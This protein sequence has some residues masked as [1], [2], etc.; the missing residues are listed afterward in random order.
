MH[1]FVSTN[2]INLVFLSNIFFILIMFGVRKNIINI[3]DPLLQ[4]IIYGSISVATLI[5]VVPLSQNGDYARNYFIFSYIFIFLII[6]IFPTKVSDFS[7]IATPIILRSK[8][9]IIMFLL[10][11]STGSI[12][13]VNFIDSGLNYE[14]RALLFSKFRII[15]ILRGAST[16][17]FAFSLGFV[18]NNRK[19]L[20]WILPI[21]FINFFTGSK[22]YLINIIANF[23][24]GRGI[25]TDY[26]LDFR[27]LIFIIILSYF[28]I[29]FLFVIQSR[30]NITWNIY[31]RLLASGDIY[32]HGLQELDIGRLDGIYNIFTYIIHPITSLFGFRMY[33][34]SLGNEIQ[35]Q[36]S[37]NFNAGG[38]NAG[39]LYLSY[40]SLQEKNYVIPFAIFWAFTLIFSRK[41]VG[42]LIKRLTSHNIL[43]YDILS[44]AI[45]YN[46]LT[47]P[48]IIFLDVGVGI[49]Q[50]LGGLI[51]LSILFIFK[52]INVKHNQR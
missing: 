44:I 7:S 45:I 36:L 27:K 25:S 43:R 32:F 50:L 38:T 15:E 12:I 1:E 33:E 39:F 6:S 34:F 42:K 22:G 20:K 47:L 2:L 35:G 14:E 41:L 26:K 18:P 16:S 51:V 46:L 37:G 3:G 21:I 11:L 24:M 49:Q 23:I 30:E 17:L 13:M 52:I 19:V 48:V 40:I 8:D 28:S 9:L 10:A 29:Y 4:F 5:L 31:Y